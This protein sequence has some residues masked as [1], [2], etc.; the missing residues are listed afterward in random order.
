MPSSSKR[1]KS[2]AV[3]GST[4]PKYSIAES[5]KAASNYDDV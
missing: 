2:S 5:S 4:Y 1:G 3:S